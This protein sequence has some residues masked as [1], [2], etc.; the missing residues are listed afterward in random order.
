MGWDGRG[1]WS[2]GFFKQ[3]QKVEQEIITM[4]STTVT[5]TFGPY[6]GVVRE[7]GGWGAYATAV[8]EAFGGAAAH[9]FCRDKRVLKRSRVNMA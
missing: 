5:G 1:L 8:W 6:D 7:E 4:I 2:E 3:A 9:V